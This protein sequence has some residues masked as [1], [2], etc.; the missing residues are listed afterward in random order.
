V[1]KKLASTVVSQRG[2]F[3][4]LP[5]LE[6]EDAAA[7]DEFFGRVCAAVKPVDIIDEMLVAD[8]VALQWEVLRWQRLKSSLV[9]ERGLTALQYFLRD[10]IEYDLYQ[11]DFVD[12]LTTILQDNGAEDQAEDFAQTLADAC[13]QNEPDAVDKVN[14]FLHGVRESMDNILYRARVH[15]S[16]ALVQEY[17]RRDPDAVKLT[18]EHLDRAGVTIDTLTVQNLAKDFDYIER[19]DRLT[20]IAESRRNT[21][22]REID[23]RRAAL[24]QTPRPIV[25]HIKEEVVDTESQEF[26]VLIQPRAGSST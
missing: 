3:G 5:I 16:K 25:E 9:R 2:L 7:Y 23:R 26:P 14:D 15:K 10:K 4:P 8:V 1:G 11:K 18:Q 22:L 12:E 19:I 6:G 17:V 20:T 24:A 13:A 21:S